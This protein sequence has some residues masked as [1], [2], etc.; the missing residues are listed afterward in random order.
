MIV[1]IVIVLAIMTVVEFVIGIVTL[2][3]VPVARPSGWVPDKAVAVYLV[4]AILGV[5]LMAGAAL[6]LSKARRST[7][8]YQMCGWMV[9]VG[10]ALAG[11]GG[12]LTSDHS[13]V[14]FLGMALMFIGPTIACLGYL[15]V[16]LDRSR[17][18]APAV[19]ADSECSAPVAASSRGS[20]RRDAR[21]GLRGRR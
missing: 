20:F 21:R 2:V 1:R 3:V 19:G 12:L 16:S 6:L 4:H 9:F 13:I 17:K 8:T 5:P 14:R 7:R 18:L 15:I 10:L 11:S